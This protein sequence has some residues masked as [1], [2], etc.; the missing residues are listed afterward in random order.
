MANDTVVVRPDGELLPIDH[1]AAPIRIDAEIRGVV[2][3]F[4]DISARRQAEEALRE[5]ARRKDEFLATLAHELRNPLAPIRNAMQ[6]MA[7]SQDD[8]VRTAEVRALIER[9]LKHMVRLIDDLM[10]VSRITQ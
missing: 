10:D 5:A 9:Q 7:V 6:I 8:F 1:S 2:L 3:I 4:R